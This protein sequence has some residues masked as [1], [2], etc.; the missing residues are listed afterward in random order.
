MNK[1]WFTPVVCLPFLPISDAKLLPE[2]GRQGGLLHL[3]VGNYIRG[4][5]TLGQLAIRLKPG[6]HKS[7]AI[8]KEFIKDKGCDKNVFVADS[9]LTCL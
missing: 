4:G 1:A 3:A 7:L 2:D 8:S 5:G 9:I 6:Q